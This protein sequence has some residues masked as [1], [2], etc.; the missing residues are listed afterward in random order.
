MSLV[1]PTF[2]QVRDFNAVK[3]VLCDECLQI[4]DILDS[5]WYYVVLNRVCR[6]ADGTD[7]PMELYQGET[8]CWECWEKRK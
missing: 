4:I 5:F 3:V 7:I 8:L 2:S 1:D 6:L